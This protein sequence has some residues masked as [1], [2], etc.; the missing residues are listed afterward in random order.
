MSGQTGRPAPRKAYAVASNVLT[1]ASGAETANASPF[2]TARPARSALNPPGPRAAITP[3][4]SGWRSLLRIQQP[5]D[6]RHELGGVVVARAPS[7]RPREGVA[8]PQANCAVV[9]RRVDDEVHE[10]P[11]SLARPRRARPPT[12]PRSTRTARRWAAARWSGPPVHLRTQAI[13]RGRSWGKASGRPLGPL[14]YAS[15]ARK[16]LVDG[17]VLNL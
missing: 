17:Q 6:C 16:E 3:V 11:L 15:A 2:A 14:H 10:T 7:G 13:A 1:P 8:T 9:G 12:A 5:S 4:R